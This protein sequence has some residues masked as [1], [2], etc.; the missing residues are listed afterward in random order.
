M[1][2]PA[3]TPETVIFS[4]LT[5]FLCRTSAASCNFFDT[6]RFDAGD[7]W[8]D[9][10][11]G[12]IVH[13]NVTY[14]R[15]QWDYYDSENVDG[16]QVSTGLHKRGCFCEAI[17]KPC[18]RLCCEFG[19]LLLPK[20]GCIR[21]DQDQGTFDVSMVIMTDNGAEE[22]TRNL[23]SFRRQM[24]VGK[25][26]RE[27]YDDYA[28]EDVFKFYEVS[29]TEI[30]REFK[31]N[32]FLEFNRTDPYDCCTRKSKKSS[33]SINISCAWPLTAIKM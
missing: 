13:A 9:N 29:R 2:L 20:R 4:I 18:I 12:V 10:A 28:Y 5:V 14:L 3:G 21:Y 19:Y 30:K 27:M 24:I 22:I 6:V 11:T 17:G 15:S 25:P 33:G 16:V 32:K 23:S 31:P 7:Y 1:E 26:C 8:H